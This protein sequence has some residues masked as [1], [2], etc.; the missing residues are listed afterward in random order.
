M[1][2]VSDGLVRDA[3][4][5]AEASGVHLDLDSALV[6]PGADLAA[7]AKVTGVDPAAWVWAGGED[8]ALLACFPAG[9]GFPEEFRLVGR[10]LP[11]GDAHPEVR[12]DGAPADPAQGWHHFS[13]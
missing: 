12:L 7:A 8:H 11:A 3:A 2:D 1:I 13:E 6:A 10:V 5:L 9:A 4:R